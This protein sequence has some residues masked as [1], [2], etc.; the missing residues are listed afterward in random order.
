MKKKM[1][2]ILIMLML[3]LSSVLPAPDVHAQST[4][5]DVNDKHGAVKEIQFLTGKKVIQ[6]YQDG[7][8]KPNNN[9]TRMQIALMLTRA[10]D[11]DLTNRP[12][13]KLKDIKKEHEKF[14]V[15]SAVIE[16]G[17]FKDVVKKDEFKPNAFVTR[18]EMATI[19]ARAYKLTGVSSV[20]FT[21]VTTKHWAYG[22]VQ[23][24]AK[25]QIVKG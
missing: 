11:Y 10:R 24:V 16:E 1:S 2:A 12:D 7:T 23:A 6:G 17:I 9:L 20:Q 8:F 22:S 18:S 13:P 5:K 15:V 14:D 25:N 3:M 19:M 21:D 4:F